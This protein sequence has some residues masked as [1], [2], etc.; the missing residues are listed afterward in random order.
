M[1][2]HTIQNVFNRCIENQIESK[3]A[4]W[5]N[6]DYDNDIITVRLFLVFVSTLHL[7]R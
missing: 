5:M 2:L 3:K 4:I 1:E 7:H 6:I